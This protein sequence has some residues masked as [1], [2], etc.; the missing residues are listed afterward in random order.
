MPHNIIHKSHYLTVRRTSSHATSTLVIA[1]DSY[2]DDR[3]LDRPAF[4]EAFFA[5]HA[6]DAVVVLSR[7]N[8]WYQYPE[9]PEALGKITVLAA[10]YD[11]VIAYGSSMGGYA[12]VRFGGWAG[13]HLALAISPQFSVDPA[14][15]PWENRWAADSARIRFLWDK[16]DCAG[17]I[18]QAIVVFDPHNS[19]ARHARLIADRVPTT[20]VSTPYA[21]HP[22]CGFL[23]ETGLLSRM[24]LQVTQRQFDA[25]AFDKARRSLKSRS[26]QYL[27][28]LSARLGPSHGRL[29][30]GLARK[31]AELRPQNPRILS[32]YGAALSDAGRHAIAGET[33]RAALTLAPDDPILLYR[34]SEHLERAGADTDA[35][36]V[37][38]RLIMK[39]DAQAYHQRFAWLY[40]RMFAQAA[41]GSN[42]R[43]ALRRRHL[44]AAAREAWRD[45]GRALRSLGRRLAS[46]ATPTPFSAANIDILVATTPA[47]PQNAVAWRRHLMLRRAAYGA[48][49]DV[50]LIG[51]SL[52]EFWPRE[53]WPLGTSVL[54]LGVAGDR[55]QN[56]LWRL[57]DLSGLPARLS[58]VVVMLGVN[59]LA[60][61]DSPAS[62]HQGLR[63]VR[64]ALMRFS[65]GAPILFVQ[66]PPTGPGGAFRSEDRRRANA[67]IA[68]DPALTSIAV[69]ALLAPSEK[70]R[71]GHYATDNIHLSF[72]GYRVLHNEVERRLWPDAANGTPGRRTVGVV[73]GPGSHSPCS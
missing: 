70:A 25:L 68:A 50:L 42:L 1:F 56:V 24:V 34:Y 13:A 32:S 61:G 65:R 40:E 4:G 62:V 12:A 57:K 69:D 9:L 67:L 43:P 7:D 8:D 17:F 10:G 23:A 49:P 64:A 44:R 60:M 46:G 19:D 30:L 31:A 18:R 16:D 14:V 2:T 72:A 45:A 53:L 48:V 36:G 11:H 71:L 54:N 6:I 37:M 15:C 59:N 73:E 3:R 33:H 38:Q 35:L 27:L 63:A 28:A 39:S 21:G 52:A 26:S 58:G 55:T 22:A 41:S 5:A 51:D 20:F 29:K 66:L 47:P